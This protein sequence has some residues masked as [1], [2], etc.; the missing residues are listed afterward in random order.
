MTGIIISKIKYFSLA[1]VLAIFGFIVA[2]LTVLVDLIYKLITGNSYFLSVSSWGSWVL[3]AITQ[4]IL[5]PI[6]YF[7]LG[8]VIAFILNIAFKV[9]KGLEIETL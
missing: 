4:I 8:Y 6:I 7:V 3:F 5:V 2:L 1:K 9:S